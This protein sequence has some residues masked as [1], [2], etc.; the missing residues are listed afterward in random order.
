MLGTVH[1]SRPLCVFPHLCLRSDSIRPR[2][3]CRAMLHAQQRCDQHS[4]VAGP[5]SRLHAAR[6]LCQPDARILQYSTPERS[7]DASGQIRRRLCSL[8]THAQQQNNMLRGALQV[9][10]TC[11]LLTVS[12]KLR[13]DG[14]TQCTR[15]LRDTS[16]YPTC[17]HVET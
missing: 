1:L 7:R 2:Q 13:R 3:L 9:Q 17:H 16:A 6:T 14:C 15:S 11:L 8:Q 4:H 5:K 10:H 12:I